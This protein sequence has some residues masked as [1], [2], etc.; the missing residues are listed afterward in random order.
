[1][2]RPRFAVLLAVLVS[3]AGCLGPE[4]AE[5]ATLHAQLRQGLA[6]DRAGFDGPFLSMTLAPDDEWACPTANVDEVDTNLSDAA[7]VL[8]DAAGGGMSGGGVLLSSCRPHETVATV[9]F[10][11]DVLRPDLAPYDVEFVLRRQGTVVGEARWRPFDVAP[12]DIG[13][14][15]CTDD[16]EAFG[17]EAVVFMCDNSFAGDIDALDAVLV[18]DDGVTLLPVS[19]DAETGGFVLP[20]D[21]TPL[22]ADGATTARLIV[23]ENQLAA[24]TSRPTCDGIAY[25]EAQAPVRMWVRRLP[26]HTAA[27]SSENE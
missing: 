4:A 24:E 5:V 7:P 25:C 1:M 6:T 21:L 9:D 16:V 27:V 10:N 26:M 17:A 23:V 15:S 3:A 18:G 22:T 2:S 20:S 8:V 13:N 11:A 12:L 19:L 14:A